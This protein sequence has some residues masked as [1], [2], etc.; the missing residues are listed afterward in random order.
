MGLRHHGQG[1]PWPAMSAG[2]S[3]PAVNMPGVVRSMMRATWRRGLGDARTAHDAQTECRRLDAR[4]M[5]RQGSG[6]SR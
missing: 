5:R 4:D 3:P 2:S 1:P 6:P